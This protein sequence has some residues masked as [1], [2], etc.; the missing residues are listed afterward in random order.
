MERG[1]ISENMTPGNM[2]PK[3][4]KAFRKLTIIQ[5][6]L[7]L[8]VLALAA[9]L[10]VVVI[11][12]IQGKNEKLEQAKVSNAAL[13]QQNQILVQRISE[14]RDVHGRNVY[15]FSCGNMSWNDAEQYCVSRGSHLTSVTSMEEQEF[16]YQ[17][18]ADATFWIGLNNQKSSK[19]IWTDGSPF[20]ETQSK[21]FWVPGQPN[22]REQTEHCATSWTINHRSWKAKNCQM[23]FKFICKRKCGSSRSCS[24]PMNNSSDHHILSKVERPVNKSTRFY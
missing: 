24:W 2:L 19:W 11:L 10:K 20:N 6:T 22:N 17:K 23:H 13:K 21:M 1:G 15:Y 5:A 16:I 14:S 4:E 7:S 3:N 18:G 12:Y 9:A 8:L